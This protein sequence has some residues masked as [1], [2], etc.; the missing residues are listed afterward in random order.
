MQ[1][2]SAP[3]Q[4]SYEQKGTAL[5]I[6][7]NFATGEVCLTD[8]WRARINALQQEAVP[9][10][11]VHAAS[12]PTIRLTSETHPCLSALLE[13]P[14]E[15]SD[16]WPSWCTFITTDRQTSDTF[17]YVGFS[18]REHSWLLLRFQHSHHFSLLQEM[19]QAK[20]LVLLI[21]PQQRSYTVPLLDP[22]LT[23]HLDCIKH[24]YAHK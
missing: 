3:A 24:T 10:E 13:L 7:S 15:T 20:Q 17:L 12:L 18:S 19:E 8:F 14:G 4:H 21:E 9:F 2:V 1:Y 23:V 11:R 22:E 5:S 6:C 16:L